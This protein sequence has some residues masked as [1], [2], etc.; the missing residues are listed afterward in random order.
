MCI[1]QDWTSRDPNLTAPVSDGA[2]P[3]IRSAHSTEL[4]QAILC[5]LAYADLFDYPLTAAELAHYLIG[6]PA[7]AQEVAEVLRGH[8][9]LAGR[10]ASSDGFFF[11][12]GRD[13]LVATRRKRGAVSARL[14]RRARRYSA[15]LGRLPFV[16]MVAVTGAL[17]MDNAGANPDIDLLVVS[18]PGRVW[19][20]RRLL[21]LAV[22]GIRLLG[23]E[24][25]PNFILAA[26]SLGI[27]DH[28]LF[29]A[30]ELAQMRP[31]GG[32]A[33]YRRM[34][35]QNGWLAAFLPN[36]QPWPAAGAESARP[37]PFARLAEALLGI[38]LLDRWE[39]WELARLQ[40]KLGADPSGAGEVACTP[41]QCKGHTGL[42][43]QHVLR[44]YEE[45]VAALAPEVQ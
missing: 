11:L 23:D 13:G 18:R 22:R 31:V 4:A 42:Y 44:R 39:Q 29:T 27:A 36:T 41:Q 40:R 1:V 12:A 32:Y 20:C 9:L 17:A 45:R 30:H 10:V 14:W 15:L 21:I 2:A 33:V 26:D 5:T 3:P 6:Q 25:C 16:R 37:G 43:R 8:P 35:A 28:D 38:R 19:I 34:L 7:T 24:I